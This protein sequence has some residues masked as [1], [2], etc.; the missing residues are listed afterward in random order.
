[1]SSNN[2]GEPGGHDKY[3]GMRELNTAVTTNVYL[4]AAGGGVLGLILSM[5]ATDQVGIIGA[6]SF[7]MAVLAGL[8][9]MFL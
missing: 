5:W 1:M 8:F 6:T 9:G 2:F 3:T 7:V 4:C